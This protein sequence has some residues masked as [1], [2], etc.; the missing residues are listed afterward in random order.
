[1]KFKIEAESERDIKAITINVKYEDDKIETV[2]CSDLKIS[3]PKKESKTGTDD[4][5]LEVY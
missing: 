3:K 2:D 4:A 1:M 5:F